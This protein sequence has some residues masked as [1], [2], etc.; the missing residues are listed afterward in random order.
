MAQRRPA[1]LEDVA[2]AC[3]YS[4]AT[5]SRVVNGAESV[6][7]KIAKVVQAAIKETGYVAN[8]A[9]RALAG[10]AS[11]NIGLAFT[12]GFREIFRNP[13]WG[14]IVEGISS[15]LYEHHYQET[16]LNRTRASAAEI[17]TYLVQRRVDG[18]IFLNSS[19]RDP[20]ITRLEAEGLPLVVFGS[21]FAGGRVGTVTL[22]DTEVG[23][24]AAQRL[25]ERGC[26]YPV[27]IAGRADLR[28]SGQ[29]VNGFSKALTDSGVKFDTGRVMRGDFTVD[30]GRQA[31]AKL[32]STHKKIDSV[33][34]SSD[35][36]A[37]GALDSLIDAGI[38]IPD[39][40]CVIGVDGTDLGELS[41]PR[42]TSIAGPSFEMGKA[43]AELTLD[44][45]EGK[46][47]RRIVFAPAL[48]ERDSA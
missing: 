1:T 25:L 26:K 15:V 11:Q 37:M 16:F 32:L 17:E 41:R 34:A 13:F 5:V 40:I 14:E 27:A 48:V 47:H 18:V 30:G 45:I 6:D 44:A 46:P 7:P 22:D 29:R 38:R 19:S 43:L 8:R 31:M 10:S 3:G 2:R 9:A 39:D 36:M 42:L 28:V 33:F 35:L 20:L 12:E 21:H 4:R 23:H 24:I